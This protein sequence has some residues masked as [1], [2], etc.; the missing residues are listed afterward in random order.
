MRKLSDVGFVRLGNFSCNKIVMQ[1]A[2][3]D[4]QCNTAFEDDFR[5]NKNDLS[6]AEN[7]VQRFSHLFNSCISVIKGQ[8]SFHKTGHLLKRRKRDSPNHGT[9][10]ER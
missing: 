10:L 3:N 4:V 1:V 7:R 5:E 8:W 6:M 9:M 2:R